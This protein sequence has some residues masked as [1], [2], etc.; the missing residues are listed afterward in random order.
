MKAS[1]IFSLLLAPLAAGSLCAQGAEAGEQA[2]AK[3]REERKAAEEAVLKAEAPLVA[4]YADFERLVAAA[5]ENPVAPLW[6]AG[7][8]EASKGAL[9][10]RNADE[11]AAAAK[12]KLSAELRRRFTDAVAALRGPAFPETLKGALA[13]RIAEELAAALPAPSADDSTLRSALEGACARVAEK[14]VQ[15]GVPIHEL[16]NRGIYKDVATAKDYSAARGALAAAADRESR[17][18]HPER[19]H[20]AYGRAPEGMVFVLGGQVTLGPNT[21]YDIDSEK[22]KAP[23]VVNLHPFYIDRTEVTNEQ[24][25]NFLLSLPKPE[26]AAHTPSNWEK[27]P[28]KSPGAGIMPPGAE[29]LPVT[30]VSYEDAAAYAAWAKKRLPTEDEWELAARGAKG[31]QYP[32]GNQYEAKKANDRNG[33]VGDLAP[34]GSFAGDTSAWGAVDLAGNA[35]EWVATLEGGKPAPLRIE[36]NALVVLRGGAYDRSPKESSAI[37]RWLWPKT[38]RVRNLGFRCAKDAF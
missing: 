12:N 18:E 32:W 1:P 24:Y 37:F 21:G 20:P 28:G 4:A 23:F 14:H 5:K 38:T 36:G 17:L 25:K 19:F 2:L 3:A 16:W 9:T 13:A 10:S 31:F 34:V 35:M 33:D 26:A 29:R 22:R 30:G 8:A 7:L 11:P 27:A 15:P 6:A